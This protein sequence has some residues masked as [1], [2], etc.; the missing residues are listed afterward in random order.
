MVVGSLF[1][2]PLSRM[3][4]G[5]SIRGP[6][7][8]KITF[9]L[10]GFTTPIDPPTGLW[11]VEPVPGEGKLPTGRTSPP[12]VTGPLIG[13]LGSIGMFG[14]P[15]MQRWNSAPLSLAQGSLFT[16]IGGFGS[17]RGA[18]HSFP[19]RTRPPRQGSSNRQ[20]P[21][22]NTVPIGQIGGFGSGRGT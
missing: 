1:D 14:V 4:F 5:P 6:L 21:S 8:W 11:P 18:T 10:V 7:G 2:G 20:A 22:L 19:T 17:G 13:G 15:R 16:T 12:P 9:G 3:F